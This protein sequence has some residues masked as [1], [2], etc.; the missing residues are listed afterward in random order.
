MIVQFPREPRIGWIHSETGEFLG[1]SVSFDVPARA[2]YVVFKA[3]R[4]QEMQ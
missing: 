3:G 1:W 4:W 2:A